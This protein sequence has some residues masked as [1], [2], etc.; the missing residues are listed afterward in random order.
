MLVGWQM[1]VLTKDVQH[2][3]DEPVVGRKG[4]QDAVDEEDVLEVVDDALAVE[5][6]HGGPQEIP[7]ERLGE[8]QT[9]RLAG[10]SMYGN[11]LL[12]GDD[13]D[14]GDYDYDVD[15]AGEQGPEEA[16]QHDKGPYG[17]G[18]EVLELLLVVGLRRGSRLGI[19]SGAVVKGG[20]R[21]AV[22]TAVVAFKK[23][24]C[25]H[26]AS[27]CKA[28]YL[29]VEAHQSAARRR[30][31]GRVRVRKKGICYRLVELSVCMAVGG[32]TAGL[33]AGRL[34]MLGDAHGGPTGLCVWVAGSMLELDVFA[35]LGHCVCGRARGWA[36]EGDGRAGT[37]QLV[38]EERA[39]GGARS[40]AT[41]QLL[42][43]EEGRALWRRTRRQAFAV[44]EEDNVICSA[45]LC[46][47]TQTLSAASHVNPCPPA[48]P[49]TADA[50]VD[51]TRR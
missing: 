20:A 13:L 2:E 44:D 30:G 33:G 19:V 7:V 11:D 17:P 8:A 42:S 31:A 23:R 12:E 15:V 3:G 18:V 6:V 48:G 14:G 50:I 24:K 25:W 16:A 10:H 39:L 36:R 45:E 43:T 32:G 47:A 9:P 37:A 26:W 1:V 22:C 29:R 35:R 51:A 49:L 5:K 38:G 28:V 46:P 27:L 40:A 34:A 21:W 4:Q 41:G